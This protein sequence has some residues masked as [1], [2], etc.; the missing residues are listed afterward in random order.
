MYCVKNI[1]NHNCYYFQTSL[2]NNP[3]IYKVILASVVFLK[4]NKIYYFLKFIFNIIKLKIY[5]NT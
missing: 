2:P 4:N 5:K 1:L 3:T